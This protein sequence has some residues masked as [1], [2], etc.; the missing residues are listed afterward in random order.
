MSLKT[1][2][3]KFS[4]F[5]HRSELS[6]RRLKEYLLQSRMIVELRRARH[7]ISQSFGLWTQAQIRSTNLCRSRETS[8]DQG[9]RR[10]RSA[11]KM[12]FVFPSIDRR[13]ENRRLEI[14]VARQILLR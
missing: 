2:Q 14:D 1:F 7:F 12:S 4:T 10:A 5:L 11:V 3:I 6:F 13:E 9:D 8:P